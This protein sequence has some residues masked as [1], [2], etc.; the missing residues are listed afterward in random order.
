MHQ[1]SQ[2]TQCLKP[3]CLWTPMDPTLCRPPRSAGFHHTQRLILPHLGLGEPST[4]STLCLGPVPR[5]VRPVGSEAALVGPKRVPEASS[6]THTRARVRAYT[7]AHTCAHTYTP[8]PQDPP[9]QTLPSLPTAP[10]RWGFYFLLQVT[11][12]CPWRAAE[13]KGVE[14]LTAPGCGSHLLD[15]TGAPASPR[16]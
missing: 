4:V 10:Q 2:A 12:S 11:T 15:D 13:H 9:T 3:F 16:R 6:Y 14:S 8:A 7:R 1:E 5:S